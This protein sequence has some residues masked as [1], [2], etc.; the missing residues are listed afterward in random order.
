MSKIQC[1]MLDDANYIICT[2]DETGHLTLNTVELDT[3][4]EMVGHSL[5]SVQHWKL[6]LCKQ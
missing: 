2:A 5:T 6:V 3:L 1:R 4:F